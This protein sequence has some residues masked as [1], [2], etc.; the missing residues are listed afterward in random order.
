MVQTTKPSFLFH[1]PFTWLLMNICTM[2]V[3][4]SFQIRVSWTNS[5][6]FL[7]AFISASTISRG[8]PRDAFAVALA[9]KALHRQSSTV[10]NRNLKFS[11]LGAKCS[12][13]SK[14][15][16]CSMAVVA[17]STDCWYISV[18]VHSVALSTSFTV[19]SNR[20]KNWL[21]SS[22]TCF[23]KYSSVVVS[24]DDT[25]FTSI[26]VRGDVIVVSLWS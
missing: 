17:I 21:E 3:K 12:D 20:D 9:L 16:T 10:S 1:Q 19:F 13:F 2:Y 24:V 25:L 22:L 11:S 15:S 5:I 26:W 7:E 23:C 18:M 14:Y 4:H 6:S 8:A